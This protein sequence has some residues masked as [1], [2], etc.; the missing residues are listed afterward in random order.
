LTPAARRRRQRTLAAV[1]LILGIGSGVLFSQPHWLASLL[2]RVMPRIVWQVEGAGPRVA[3]TFDDGPSPE[4]TPRVLDILRRRGARATFFLI[5][6]HALAHA[7]LVARIRA[8]GHQVGNHYWNKGTTL[9]T[10]EEEFMTQVRRTEAVLGPLRAPKVFRPP[11]GLIRPSHR[12]A[13][14]RL[15]Y[16]CVIGSA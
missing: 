6:G 9:F 14:E 12:G 5:G 15:G 11:G 3:L 1:A 4:F 8:E 16:R 7:D 10:D 13:V 2:A